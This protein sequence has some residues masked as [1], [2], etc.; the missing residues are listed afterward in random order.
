MWGFHVAPCGCVR[1][2]KRMSEGQSWKVGRALN[3]T[4]GCWG[5][6]RPWEALKI[7]SKKML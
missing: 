4:L 3:T 5:F 2:V 7:L 1:H 6:G